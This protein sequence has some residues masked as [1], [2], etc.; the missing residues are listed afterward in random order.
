MRG[1][2]LL[3][4]AYAILDERGKVILSD[5]KV[6]LIFKTKNEAKFELQPGEGETVQK[7][8]IYAA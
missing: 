7:V 3:K 8:S 1:D 6:I 2:K 4:V 5:D